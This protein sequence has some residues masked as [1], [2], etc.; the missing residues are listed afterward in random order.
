VYLA[1]MGATGALLFCVLAAILYYVKV[2]D[3]PVFVIR[4]SF[5]DKQSRYMD[6]EG[7]R[8]H[9]KLE[10]VSVHSQA[11]VLLI[12]GT[13]SSLHTWD[14]WTK[15]FVQNGFRVL[16]VDLP[17]YGITG[18]TIY[19]QEDQVHLYESH[20][21]SNL[22]VDYDVH[23][24]TQ[25]LDKLGIDKFNV[26]GNSY[27][28]RISAELA[29][30]FPSRVQKLVLISSAGLN[31]GRHGFLQL[32]S[33]PYLSSWV[34]AFLTEGL[35]RRA[36]YSVYLDP[37]KVTDQLV[38]RY[39]E[40]MLREGNRQA[41]LDRMARMTLG[42]PEKFSQI[43]APTLIMWGKHDSWIS[44]DHAHK[45][46]SLIAKSKLKLYDAG[47]VAMEEIPE[48]TAADAI[49]FLTSDL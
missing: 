41:L 1:C 12:H 25:L 26:A 4:A 29:I 20:Q 5:A 39:H 28:G 18:A 43:K 35:I 48:Q 8:V 30:R 38:Q 46:H 17:G 15:Y 32:A 9:Y 13:A 23:I 34:I 3:I 7:L 36:V 11:P 27:G 31:T 44:V 10:G 19:Q 24:L 14:A 33:I 22:T 49:S 16:R 21:H 2:Q 40:L 37:S 42:K 6:V 47:H 45:F